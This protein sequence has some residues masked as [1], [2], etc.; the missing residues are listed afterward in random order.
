MMSS[1]DLEDKLALKI[2]SFNMLECGRMANMM[3][4]ASACMQIILTL[5]ECGAM[6]G[7]MDKANS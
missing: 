5:K 4:M 6:A 2:N 3:V 7:S 1:M